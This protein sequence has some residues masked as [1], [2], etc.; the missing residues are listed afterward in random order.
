MSFVNR[1]AEN[2]AIQTTAPYPAIPDFSH[3][4]FVSPGECLV[5]GDVYLDLANPG[6]GPFKAM[7]RQCAGSKNRYVAETDVR[8]S[9]WDLLIRM[10]SYIGLSNAALQHAALRSADA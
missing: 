9:T 10:T 6:R 1:R 8:P 4:P 2:G 5:E 3:L 7:P